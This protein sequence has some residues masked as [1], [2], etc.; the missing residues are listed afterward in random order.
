MCL[1]DSGANLCDAWGCPDANP[2]DFSTRPIL[3]SR[4]NAESR[5]SLWT[6]VD[7]ISE[8]MGSALQVELV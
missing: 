7:Q 5:A 4:V 6:C 8:G 3:E 2:V 1:P